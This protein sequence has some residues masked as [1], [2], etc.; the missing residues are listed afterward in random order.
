V[1]QSIALPQT[2]ETARADGA[3]FGQAAARQAAAAMTRPGLTQAQ[4]KA[5]GAETAGAVLAKAD[6]LAA[7]GLDRALV[8]AWTEA[9]AEAFN[10]ELSRAASLCPHQGPSTKAR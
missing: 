6:S 3:E 5:L 8:E 4:V 7:A 1:T 10:A 9:A 2:V